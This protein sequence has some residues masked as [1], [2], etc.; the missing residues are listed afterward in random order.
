MFVNEALVKQFNKLIDDEYKLANA[1]IFGSARAYNTALK[2]RQALA[3]EA[4][5]LLHIDIRHTVGSKEYCE[6][7]VLIYQ[8][9]NAV[10]NYRT[11][12]RLTCMS[13]G[14]M[15]KKYNE[16]KQL[17]FTWKEIF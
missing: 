8:V 14:T 10:G 9:A 17:Y 7:A 16:G 1:L 2:K 15:R 12:A 11:L 6:S 5:T 13:E 4:K 3:D